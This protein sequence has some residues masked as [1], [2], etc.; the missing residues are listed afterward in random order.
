MLHQ[1]LTPNIHHT[2]RRLARPIPRTQRIH[3]PPR[4]LQIDQSRII[5]TRRLLAQIDRVDETRVLERHLE[6][7]V[8]AYV[9]DE[10]GVGEGGNGG[11]AGGF[12][13][14]D[15]LFGGEGGAGVGVEG[16]DAGAEGG[17]RGEDLGGGGVRD[18]D[19]A[20]ED[21]CAG[22]A[23]A[24][25]LRGEGSWFGLRAGFLLAVVGVALGLGDGEGA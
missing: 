3:K 17:V 7:A 18:G 13:V 14:G 24:R 9:G 6:D 12:L 25:V 16:E 21:G 10:R 2:N 20:E 11:P 22:G 19:G 5:H 8:D 23:G 1:L 4:G 15:D